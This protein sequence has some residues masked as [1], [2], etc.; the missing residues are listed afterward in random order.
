MAS[1][2]FDFTYVVNRSIHIPVGKKY[3]HS[4]NRIYVQAYG[5]FDK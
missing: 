5:T 3:R 1:M 2:Y 4:V